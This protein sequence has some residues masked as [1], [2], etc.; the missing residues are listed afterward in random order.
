[1]TRHNLAAYTPAGASYPAY[2]SINAEDD[3]RVSITVRS[4][5]ED[6]GGH[7]VIYL[8]RQQIHSIFTDVLNGII[9]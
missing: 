5:V 8:D 3:G 7:A 1:M 9:E 4:D 6:G 2:I